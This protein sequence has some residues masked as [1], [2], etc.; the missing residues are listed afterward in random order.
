VKKFC[1]IICAASGSGGMEVKMKKTRK[2]LVVLLV[3]SLLVSFLP[4]DASA[5]E[6]YTRLAGQTRYQTS[7]AVAESFNSGQVDDVVIAIRK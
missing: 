2:L 3:L 1:I 5:S 6:S 4:Q 7:K